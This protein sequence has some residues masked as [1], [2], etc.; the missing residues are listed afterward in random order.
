MEPQH[1]L[2]TDRKGI[3]LRRFSRFSFHKFTSPT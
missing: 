3:Q 1:C 2:L